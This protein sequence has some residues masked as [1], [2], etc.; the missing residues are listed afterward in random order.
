MRFLDRNEKFGVMTYLIEV[1][2]H[3]PFQSLTTLDVFQG[4]GEIHPLGVG[5]IQIVCVVLVPLLNSCKHLILNCADNMHVLLKEDKRPI[6]RI[7]IFLR[8]LGHV[9]ITMTYERMEMEHEL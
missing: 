5:D 3:I 4:Q 9:V 2:H 6:T 8:P 7:S 1:N